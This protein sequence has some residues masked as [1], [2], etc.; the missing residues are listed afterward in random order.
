M[1][2]VYCSLDLVE[3]DIVWEDLRI[4][5]LLP[6]YMIFPA[7]EP[8]LPAHFVAL[9]HPED[10]SI[11]YWG[12]KDV[13]EAYFEKGISHLKSAIIRVDIS[14]DLAQIDENSFSDEG[15]DSELASIG[16]KNVLAISGNGAF[17]R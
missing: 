5:K 16:I 14:L 6:G 3:R 12:D 9:R 13:L 15:S 11:V 8:Y 17:I 1:I 4:Q 7:I 10:R 2:E